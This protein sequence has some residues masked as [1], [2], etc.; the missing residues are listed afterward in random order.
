MT[1]ELTT[2]F[3]T[4][5]R[6]ASNSDTIIL[7]SWLTRILLCITCTICS[8]IILAESCM[9]P[10]HAQLS[11][12]SLIIVVFPVIIIT[13]RISVKNQSL[14]QASY[15]NK[16]RPRTRPSFLFRCSAIPYSAFYKHPQKT[17][18]PNNYTQ[19]HITQACI[20]RGVSREK[21]INGFALTAHVARK[22][23]LLYL[24][25]IKFIHYQ[26]RKPST[27]KI[28]SSLDVIVCP[29]YTVY[30]NSLLV[31]LMLTAGQL[32]V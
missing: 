31:Q 28:F 7:I 8:M 17:G 14:W 18:F 3:G 25:F 5:I 27:I 15:F 22:K 4:F 6:H 16:P 19:C 23:F 26:E 11:A 13:A 2:A 21:F 1:R 30:C 10:R 32:L 20:A 29:T 12:Q 9:T 24:I